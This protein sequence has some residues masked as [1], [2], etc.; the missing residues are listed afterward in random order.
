MLNDLNE[1][2]KFKPESHGDLSPSSLWEYHWKT[3]W[4]SHVFHSD[5][6][7]PQFAMENLAE[8]SGPLTEFDDLP[9]FSS[10]DFPMGKPVIFSH[11]GL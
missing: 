6:F 5:N 3:I 10:G 4:E 2:R 7:F 11:T 9:C 1:G 8:A